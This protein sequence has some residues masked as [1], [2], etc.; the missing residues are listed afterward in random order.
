MKRIPAITFALLLTVGILLSG[1]DNEDPPTSPDLTWVTVFEDNFDG[2]TI[3]TSNWT[4]NESSPPPYSL[5]GSGE[6]KI[7]GESS[8]GD[9][10]FVYNTAISGNYVRVIAKFRTTQKDS[11]Q[12]DVDIAIILNIDSTG[13][14]LYALL[15]SSDPSGNSRDYELKILKFTNGADSVLIEDSMGGMMPQ[16]IANNDYILKGTNSDG[17]ITFT[18]EDGNGNELKTVSFEDS[19]Y[20]GGKIA[21]TGDL[22]IGTTGPQ[23]IYYDYVIVQKYQ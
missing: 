15:L 4:Q 10:T 22:N 12:D 20:S 23:S 2:A 19:S 17:T 21:I 16:I 7:D 6:L 9:A 5:T 13:N 3:N 18:I 8:G 11:V 1:C 14:N